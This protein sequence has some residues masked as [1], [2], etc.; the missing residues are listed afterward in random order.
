MF[1]ST[2]LAS[3]I[4]LG[5]GQP[6]EFT[7]TTGWE[8]E[9]WEGTHHVFVHCATP[10]D[11]AVQNVEQMLTT[12]GGWQDQA[13]HGRC[14]STYGMIWAETPGAHLMEFTRGSKF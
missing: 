11:E 13:A 3:L 10:Q 9:G 1:F 14:W 6:K 8:H 2:C 5:R 12:G 7:P 4:L